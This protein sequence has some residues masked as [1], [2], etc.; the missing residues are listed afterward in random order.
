MRLI[1]QRLNKRRATLRRCRN[2]GNDGAFPSFLLILSATILIPT[3]SP[4]APSNPNFLIIVSDNQGWADIGYHGSRI[5]TPVL[6]GLAKEGV[7]LERFYAYAMCSPSRAVRGDGPSSRRGG[8]RAPRAQI[9]RRA[10]RLDARPRRRPVVRLPTGQP[11]EA[12]V[13]AVGR[14]RTSIAA[15]CD[16]P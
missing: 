9:G 2:Y 10:D 8:V 7:R 16:R 4:A 5:R 15:A 11:P 6:D 14:R 3:V 13:R 1:Q 12:C